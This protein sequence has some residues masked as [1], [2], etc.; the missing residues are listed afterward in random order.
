MTSELSDYDYELPDHCI[1]QT[2]ADKR[3]G[4]KLFVVGPPEQHL[5]FKDIA[6]SI[7]AGALLVINDTRVLRARLFGKK[8]TGGVV[9]L[10]LLE[11]HFLN[12]TANA[13]NQNVDKAGQG[14]TWLAMGKEQ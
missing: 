10:L 3:S 7:P 5:T 6:S 11:P 12:D 1:A 8:S 2:P 13:E 9:E 14:E 4:S